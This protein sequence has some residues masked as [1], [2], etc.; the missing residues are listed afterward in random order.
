MRA[1][2][3]YVVGK[4]PFANSLMDF[5]CSTKALFNLGG[6]NFEV[7]NSTELEKKASRL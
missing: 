4:Y 2:P 1:S 3:A 6:F 7:H 5:Y